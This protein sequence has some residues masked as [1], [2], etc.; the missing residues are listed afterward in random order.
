MLGYKCCVSL[1]YRCEKLHVCSRAP[2]ATH[3]SKPVGLRV[4]TGSTGCSKT[5]ML[6]YCQFCIA[7][8]HVKDQRLLVVEGLHVVPQMTAAVVCPEAGQLRL[9]RACVLLFCVKS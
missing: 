5:L 1:L 4:L 7:L 8:L 9:R 3:Y 6:Q 2:I